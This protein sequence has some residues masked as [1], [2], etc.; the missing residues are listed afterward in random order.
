MCDGPD[1]VVMVLIF[2]E[3]IVKRSPYGSPACKVLTLDVLQVDHSVNY[4]LSGRLRRLPC[5]LD[6]ISV[7]RIVVS[8]S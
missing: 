6:T 8:I 5:T 4:L 2:G 3:R 7:H 1:L